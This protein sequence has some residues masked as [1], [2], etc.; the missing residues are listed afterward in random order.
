MHIDFY[1]GKKAYA[2]TGESILLN[3]EPL[4]I[5]T[6]KPI[7]LVMG[8]PAYIE[9]TPYESDIP[10]YFISEKAVTSIL[11]TN[12]FYG[13]TAQPHKDIFKLSY[14]KN[15]VPGDLKLLAVNR[16]HVES[17]LSANELG[18]DIKVVSVTKLSEER[19]PSHATC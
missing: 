6:V 9:V 3:N 18:S 12:E 4:H 14:L 5:G 2:I 19:V 7:Q 1:I 17:L 10:T 16:L 13:G 15:G 11:P 8:M